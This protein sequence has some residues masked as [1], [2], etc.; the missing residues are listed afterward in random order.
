[1][2]LWVACRH[3]PYMIIENP[4]LLEILWILFEPVDVPSAHT[5]SQDVQEVFAISQW[6]VG[7]VLQ[8]Y[9]GKLH[10]GVDSWA[11]SNIFSFLGV[12]VTCCIT[13]GLITMI[14]DFIR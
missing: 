10:L 2:A 9:D 13:G 4:K 12:T 11:A 8:E 14:L 1:L 7:Y 6:E 3:C 5:L